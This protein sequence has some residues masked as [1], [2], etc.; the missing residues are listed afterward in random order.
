[1]AFI[2]DNRNLQGYI[3]SDERVERMRRA[4]RFKVIQ[5]ELA[6]QEEEAALELNRTRK[7]KAAQRESALAEEL[8]LVKHD[9]LKDEKML[10]YVQDTAPELRALKLKLNAAYVAKERKNQMTQNQIFKKQLENEDREYM[11]R[12]VAESDAIFAAQAEKQRENKS[13]AE[14]VA[15]LQRDQVALKE[16]QA[17]AARE[18]FLR[19]KADVDAIVAKVQEKD[20]LDALEHIDKQRT[21]KKEHETFQAQRD[22]RKRHDAQRKAEED[23]TIL[24]YMEEQNQRK[25]SDEKLKKERESA[26]A[27][28]LEEQSRKI[29]AERG[30]KEE[31]EQLINEYYEEQRAQKSREEERLQRERK[32]RDRDT[33]IEANERQMSLK[34]EKRQQELAKEQEFRRLMMEKFALED[35]LEQQNRLKQNQLKAEHARKVQ[36]L[37][38]EKRKLLEEDALRAAVLA[39]QNRKREEYTRSLIQRERIRML[40][41]HCGGLEGF[42]PKGLTEEDMEIVRSIT[43]QSK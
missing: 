39:E 4:N 34:Q 14:N 36:Q 30:K 27:R 23:A 9:E 17:R 24:K 21:A 29:E 31:L 41:E 5:G 3:N 37:I 7:V 26:K 15:Q 42:L 13:G 8:L 20:Y 28:V 12:V 2:S 10:Q 6:Q 40:V 33:M 22:E 32:Q 1:M 43:A 19:E 18:Q 11:D 35:R 38:D 16:E 25:E